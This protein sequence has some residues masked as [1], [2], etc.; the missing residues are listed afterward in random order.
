M[1]KNFI[2]LSCN[3]KVRYSSPQRAGA[4]AK[5]CKEER[6]VSLRI[7]ACGLC[8]GFHLTSQLEPPVLKIEP[9]KGP[10]QPVKVRCI[11]GHLTTPEFHKKQCPICLENKKAK[12]EKIETEAEKRTKEKRCI[13]GHLT[14]PEF[15]RKQCP[16]CLEN[17]LKKAEKEKI[18]AEKRIKEK[19]EQYRLWAEKQ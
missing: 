14:T 6:Q 11:S 1:S 12:K 9:A 15:H 7:Y 13:S 2:S 17:K 5:Q 18:E 8:G 16:I 10:E 4:V 3:N 19:L